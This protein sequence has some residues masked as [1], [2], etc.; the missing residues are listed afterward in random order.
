M[1]CKDTYVICGR[2]IGGC[3]TRRLRRFP[4]ADLQCLSAVGFAM[5]FLGLLLGVGSHIASVALLSR[6]HEQMRHPAPPFN[7]CRG[8]ATVAATTEGWQHSAG[9]ESPP[10]L[11]SLVVP[12][13]LAGLVLELLSGAPTIALPHGRT[14]AVM[15]MLSIALQR[16]SPSS[17]SRWP[18]LPTHSEQYICPSGLNNMKLSC[19]E[20]RIVVA[21]ACVARRLG[22]WACWE[23]GWSCA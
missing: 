12:L 11:Q 20:V 9:P 16:V 13:S 15:L 19:V 21:K 3:L 4:P 1:A 2:S 8:T 18:L 17:P 7:T 22:C 6:E 14:V 10:W 5:L 23:A